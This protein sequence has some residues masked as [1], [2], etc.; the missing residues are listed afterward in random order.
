ML[1]KNA[2]FFISVASLISARF[3]KVNAGKGGKSSW[4]CIRAQ[5]LPFKFLVD[6]LSPVTNLQSMWLVLNCFAGLPH[7]NADISMLINF[8]VK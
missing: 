2:L 5:Y 7:T 3:V 4:A 6:A 8:F 1:K